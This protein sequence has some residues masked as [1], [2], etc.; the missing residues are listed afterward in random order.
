M[1]TVTSMEDFVK[2]RDAKRSVAT[3]SNVHTEFQRAARLAGFPD[4]V[5]LSRKT[6]LDRERFIY[7]HVNQLLD[8]VRKRYKSHDLFPAEQVAIRDIGPLVHQYCADSREGTC[9]FVLRRMWSRAMDG[10]IDRLADTVAP[11][12]FGP[13][14]RSG[15]PGPRNG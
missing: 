7:T 1:G 12:V 14:N 3:Y 6:V 4:F 13:P 10:V 8:P 15:A 11:I 9:A 2:A 5:G